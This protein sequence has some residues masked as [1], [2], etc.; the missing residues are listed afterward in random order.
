MK[1][2][3][4]VTSVRIAA[5]LPPRARAP[6]ACGAR[7]GQPVSAHDAEGG[8]APSADAPIDRRHGR[9]A[10][11]PRV[12]PTPTDRSGQP[13]AVVA[14]TIA[15]GEAAH[16]DVARAALGARDAGSA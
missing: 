11:L 12:E 15:V 2:L 8:G 13:Q 5:S 1:P 4:P 9:E 16:G 6:L 14:A 10:V 7:P 3:A